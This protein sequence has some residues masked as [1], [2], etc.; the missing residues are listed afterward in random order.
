VMSFES[1]LNLSNHFPSTFWVKLHVVYFFHPFF[2]PSNF[3][4]FDLVSEFLLSFFELCSH[5]RYRG[6]S[7]YLKTVIPLAYCF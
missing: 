7:P 3:C 4:L 6:V 1:F 2:V 5:T